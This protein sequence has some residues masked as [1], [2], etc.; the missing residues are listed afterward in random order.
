[1]R[2]FEDG[3]YYVDEEKL[4]LW[5][6]HVSETGNKFNGNPLSLESIKMHT[7]ALINLWGGGNQKLIK[8]E[9]TNPNHP[10][11]YGVKMFE[12]NL[13]KIYHEIKEKQ[14]ADTAKNSIQD[15]YTYKQYI[16][17][18]TY[19][20][21]KR[22]GGQTAYRDRMALICN[23]LMLLRGENLRGASLQHCS[24]IEFDNEGAIKDCPALVFQFTG[25]KMNQSYKTQYSGAIRHKDVRLCAWG[26]V[27]FYFFYHFIIEGEKFPDFTTNENWYNINVLKPAKAPRK[28]EMLYA[29]QNQSLHR[30]FAEV[31]VKSSHTTHAGRGLGAR[32]GKL[33]GASLYMICRIGRWDSGSLENSYFTHFN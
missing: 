1:M 11:R 21:K 19:Y 15:D 26:S 31:G 5:L 9:K 7:K 3:S 8:P 13:D 10:R 4:F 12:G 16:I 22:G 2:K 6:K 29:A 17:L 24:M 32:I 25:G 30:V 28:E 14:F 20:F 27:A 33:N 23:H 18:S